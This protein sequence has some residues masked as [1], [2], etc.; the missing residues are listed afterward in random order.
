MK[1]AIVAVGLAGATMTMTG[2]ADAAQV[3]VSLD[4]GNVAFG[5]QDG[6]WDQGHH[7][8]HWRNQREARYYRNASGSQYHAYRHDRDPDHGWQR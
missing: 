2:T 4:V 7:W 1:G 6:Y 8:H 3:G 5:Y